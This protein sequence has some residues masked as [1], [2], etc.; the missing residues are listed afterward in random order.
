MQ[1]EARDFIVEQ[2]TAT[3]MKVLS[4]RGEKTKFFFSFFSFVCFSIRAGNSIVLVCDQTGA[5][6]TEENRREQKRTEIDSLLEKSVEEK[7]CSALMI[8]TLN[9]N[10]TSSIFLISSVDSK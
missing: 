7:V 6:R 5:T 2:Y 1:H 10:V 4:E 8:S 9:F 3:L